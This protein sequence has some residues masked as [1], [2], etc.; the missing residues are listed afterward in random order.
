[1]PSVGVSNANFQIGPI[2]TIPIPI[3]GTLHKCC[4][5]VIFHYLNQKQNWLKN[6]KIILI[7]RVE[8]L[9]HLPNC[10]STYCRAFSE[11]LAKLI[12]KVHHIKSGWSRL[13]LLL[14][15]FSKTTMDSLSEC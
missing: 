15:S 4:A 10:N 13:H 14:I 11:I 7:Q 3:L 9:D 5:L 1:M 12:G 8:F 6:I 2:H